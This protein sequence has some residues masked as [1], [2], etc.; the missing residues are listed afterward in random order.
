MSVTTEPEVK[1]S[2]SANGKTFELSTPQVTENIERLL[3][4]A[5][6]YQPFPI[7]SEAEL[8]GEFTP[9]DVLDALAD[10]LIIKHRLT[11]ADGCTIKFFFRDHGGKSKGRAVLGKTIKPTGLL[12]HFSGAD[13]I[14]WIAAD[15]LRESG[16]SVVDVEAVLFHELNHVAEKVDDETG[17]STYLVAGHDWEGF[18]SEIAHYGLRARHLTPLVA[19][20]K[21][22]ALGLAE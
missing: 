9:S 13:F 11:V 2:V 15:H 21:Q 8:D 17:E 3:R 4:A 20:V 10:D 7:P 6:G 22:L 1:V 5:P 18:E 16:A 14:V 19:A 12:H